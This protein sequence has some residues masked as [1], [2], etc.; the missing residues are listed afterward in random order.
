[1]RFLFQHK[2]IPLKNKIKIMTAVLYTKNV[3]VLYGKQY[4]GVKFTANY[5]GK[6]NRK[7]FIQK[8]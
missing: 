5:T 3:M 4:K 1:M 6:Y 7:L 8:R 2:K